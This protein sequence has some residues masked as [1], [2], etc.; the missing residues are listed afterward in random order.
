[1]NVLQRIHNRG[2]APM[3]M[4]SV[5]AMK[6]NA[7]RLSGRRDIR[8]PIHDYQM[9]LDT[10]DSGLSRA[11]IL[12]RERELDTK[13][14]LE[15]FVKPGM[16][17]FDIGANIGYY[18][19][20]MLRLLNGNGR[21]IAIEPVPENVFR[22][23]RNL[24]LN[25]YNDVPILQ[26]AIS[27]SV[28]ERTFHLSKFSNLGTFH[29]VQSSFQSGE[30]LTIRTV[31]IGDIASWYGKPD[32]IRMD[33]EGHEFEAIRGMLPEIERKQLVPII[34][35]ETHNDRYGDDHNMESVLRYLFALGYRTPMM[36]SG[37][38]TAAECF[39]KR[40]YQAFKTLRSDATY[41]SLYR[42]IKNEDAIE[43]ICRGGA[44]TVVLA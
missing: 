43:F 12:F 39:F 1:M 37:S 2:L 27:D 7:Y 36:S 29:P 8:C 21:V 33:I 24:Q 4:A 40:G 20:M 5:R 44:R 17:I 34:V 38:G 18:T 15:H 32:L 10:S 26:A 42:D 28:S 13:F 16:T 41:L 11:L 6:R 22:L 23:W 31:I 25:D 19:L 14:M 3:A 35:F 30:T 9:D